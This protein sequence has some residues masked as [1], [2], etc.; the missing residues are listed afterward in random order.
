MNG[1]HR[2]VEWLHMAMGTRLDR[3]KRIATRLKNECGYSLSEI[4]GLIGENFER[5]YRASLP[6]VRRPVT[7]SPRHRSTVNTRTVLFRWKRRVNR[8]NG[9]YARRSVPT[10]RSFTS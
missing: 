10:P 6:G 8:Q 4:S 3:W 9:P 2:N 7:L 5:V 1:Y